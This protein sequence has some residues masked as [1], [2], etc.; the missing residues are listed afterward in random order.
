MPTVT[1]KDGSTIAYDRTGDGPPL[2]LVAGSFQ[3]RKAMGAYARPLDAHFTVYAY[4]RRGRGD[5]GD[6]QPYAIQRE[7]DDIAALIDDA[8]GQAFVFGG[9]S[10]AVLSLDAV[11]HG[12]NIP[13][14]AI[15]EPPFAVDDSRPPVPENLVDELA[16]L[17]AAGQ[18]SEAA[19]AYLTK[20]GVLTGDVV[21]QMAAQP[22]WQTD[23]VP[24]AHTLLYDAIIMS[25]TLTGGPLPTDR[26]TH[27]TQ[28]TLIMN[29]TASFPWT[30]AGANALATVLPNATRQTFEGEAHE[31]SPAA[32][33]PAL[34]EFFI[35]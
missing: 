22:Y 18:R 5:S 34:V 3:D 30:A 27:V 4:D 13:K 35:S 33:A 2:I 20:G 10:G 21:A 11:E 24:V 31:V 16:T 17:I 12:L 28:P 8:G 6:N 23:V 1:S 15:Y 9:S 7:I 25:G 32:L 29:G 26:W 14:L 19:A